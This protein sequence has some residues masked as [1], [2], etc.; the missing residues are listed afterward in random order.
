MTPPGKAEQ[1][2]SD[3]DVF[4]PIPEAADPLHEIPEGGLLI[5]GHPVVNAGVEK[6]AEQKDRPGGDE[7][8]TPPANPGSCCHE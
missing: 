8:E 2:K 1:R 6:E 4:R 5:L 7:Q 3:G